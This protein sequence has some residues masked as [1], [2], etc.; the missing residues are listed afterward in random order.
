MFPTARKILVFLGSD[1]GLSNPAV[2]MCLGRRGVDNGVVIWGVLVISI[3][4]KTY[5]FTPGWPH[6][7]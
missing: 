7:M 5:S 3:Y 6:R 4:P 1:A 2:R